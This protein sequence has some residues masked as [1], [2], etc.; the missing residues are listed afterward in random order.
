MDKELEADIRAFLDAAE[1][2]FGRGW[3][4]HHAVWVWAN[5]RSA[6]KGRVMEQ[7]KPSEI[8]SASKSI[9]L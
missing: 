5:E 2:T 4:A 3:F 8:G 1:K 6:G 7:P 9:G